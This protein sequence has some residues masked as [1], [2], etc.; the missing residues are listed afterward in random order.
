MIT[1]TVT[2]D[3]AAPA[4]TVFAYIADFSNNAEWQSG[5]TS[6]EWTSPPP[7]HVGSR[8]EQE[9]SYKGVATSYEVTAMQPGRSI[10]VK[11][12]PGAAVPTTVTRTVEELDPSICRVRVDLIG[13]LK[14]LRRL[15]TPL[16]RR[17]VRRSIESD[18]RALKRRFESS[19]EDEPGRD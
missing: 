9:M 1:V 2:T 16:L 18:Y 14:G 19:D 7:I 15:A 11:S 13:E 12:Q 6:T 10:T 5:I 8:Y 17:T 4:D 3:I